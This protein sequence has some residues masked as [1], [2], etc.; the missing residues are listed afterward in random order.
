[1]PLFVTILVR[2]T[3]DMRR[4]RDV[5]CGV[6]AK[7]MPTTTRQ[8]NRLAFSLPL[9]LSICLPVISPAQSVPKK[10]PVKDTAKKLPPI[11]EVTPVDVNG[12]K[13]TR[14]KIDLQVH[15]DTMEPKAEA[16]RIRIDDRSEV[17]FLLTNL[18]P[19]DV[20][21]RSTE[22][23]TPNTEMPVGE[24]LVTTVA[25]LGGFSVSPKTPT[26]GLMKSFTETSISLPAPL[27]ARH[28][29]LDDPGILTHCKPGQ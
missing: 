16:R 12:H 26:T 4:T 29:A 6:Q 5:W 11:T 20:C 13:V 17:Q 2:R 7:Y 27:T 18:S 1:M 21:T 25:G 23:P 14:I 8:P 22:T 24:S 15:P 28:K 3:R 10:D 9:L 19:L